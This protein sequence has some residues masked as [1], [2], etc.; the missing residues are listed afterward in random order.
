MS[1]VNKYGGYNKIIDI[2]SSLAKTQITNMFRNHILL[3]HTVKTCF[4]D[5]STV[6]M[7]TYV[8]NHILK[9][10]KY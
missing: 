9:P 5:S 8:Y 4:H 1:H 6:N 10:E 7:A 2:I 3:W